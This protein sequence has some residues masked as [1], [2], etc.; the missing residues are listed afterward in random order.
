MK[1][2][3]I[4]LAATLLLSNHYSRALLLELQSTHS[5]TD[6]SLITASDCESRF[7]RGEKL[8]LD[9]VDQFALELLPEMTSSTAEEFMDSREVV[10]E[11]ADVVKALMMVKGIGKKKALLFSTYL[12]SSLRQDGEDP[13]EEPEGE[14][15]GEEEVEQDE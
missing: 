2:P 11:E 1:M 8:L 15:G 9:E 4:I 10:I 12:E 7:A 14:E 3:H 13:D 5:L 6:I